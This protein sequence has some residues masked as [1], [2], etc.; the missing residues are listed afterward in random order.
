VGQN[1]DLFIRTL[2]IFDSVCIFFL[3]LRKLLNPHLNDF[4]YVLIREVLMLSFFKTFV[5]ISG[6]GLMVDTGIL[7]TLI[8]DLF[9]AA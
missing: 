2:G 6:L 7:L 8:E 3:K 9:S 4:D 1:F 5:T